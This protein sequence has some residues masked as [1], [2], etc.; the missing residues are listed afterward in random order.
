ME[1]EEQQFTS[2]IRQD[3]DFSDSQ[4]SLVPDPLQE[5]DSHQALQ[6]TMCFFEYVTSA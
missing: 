5:E 4:L 3:D 2:I 6:G 1:E